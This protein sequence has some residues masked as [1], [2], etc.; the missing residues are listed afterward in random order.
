[1]KYVIII[2]ARMNSSRFPGKPLKTILGLPMIGHCYFRS[3]LAKKI[4]DV[5]VATCD[6]EIKDYIEKIGGDVILTSKKHERASTR[7][8][9]AL[10]ILESQRNVK[11]DVVIMVQGD[12][13]LINPKMI[14]KIRSSFTDRN[15]AISNLMTIIKTKNDFLNKNNVKVVIDNEKNALYFS[16]EPIPSPW[17]D[18]KSYPKYMQTGII[19]FRS[20]ALK[21]FNETNTSLLED[22]EGIDLNRVL[23]HGDKVKMIEIDDI[24][25]GVDIP[26]DLKKVE[27]ILKNDMTNNYYLKSYI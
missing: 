25:I 17:K 8:G 1:M 20:N 18:W 2:P 9:E 14:D 16:R 23:E 26:Q 5:I 21:K 13:P 10:K 4:S 24:C 11:Y 22:V 19:A 27:K 15:V 7:A 12:E 3:K 6:N